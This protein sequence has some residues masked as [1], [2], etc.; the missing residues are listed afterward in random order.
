LP[1][2]RDG[3]PPTTF[4][5]RHAFAG[6]AAYGGLLL[7]DGMNERGLAAGMLWIDDRPASYNYT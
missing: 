1:V 4:P 2:C 6:L 3:C 5:I 7:A